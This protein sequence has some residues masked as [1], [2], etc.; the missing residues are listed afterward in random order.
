[1]QTVFHHIRGEQNNGGFTVAVRMR[2]DGLYAASICKC[3]E[4][5]DYNEELGEAIALARMKRGQFFVQDWDALERTLAT[6]SAKLVGQVGV[7]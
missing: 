1:M 2:P 7:S 3:K 4:G 5:Q 6:L